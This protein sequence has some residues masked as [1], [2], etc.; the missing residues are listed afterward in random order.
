MKPDSVARA[1]FFLF[2]GFLTGL[3]LIGFLTRDSVLEATAQRDAALKESKAL[4]EEPECGKVL[5][6]QRECVRRKGT[7][8]PV[9]HTC[10]F[11]L[12]HQEIP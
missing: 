7:Y 11:E 5:Q 8:Y 10:V 4:A 2:V 12:G 1:L 9:Q 3:A 6:Y